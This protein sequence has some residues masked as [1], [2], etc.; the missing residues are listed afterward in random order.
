MAL[1]IPLLLFPDCFVKKETVSGI[2]GKTQGVSKAI[3][4]PNTPNKKIPQRLLP[5]VPPSPA[6]LTGFFKSK[7][8][9]LIRLVVV[10]PPSKGTVKSELP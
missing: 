6:L 10:T 7:L 5:S 3:K 1:P 4:P 8:A 2:I 9:I